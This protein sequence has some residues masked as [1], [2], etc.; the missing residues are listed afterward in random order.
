MPLT[1]QSPIQNQGSQPLM[2]KRGVVEN[3]DGGVELF[4]GEFE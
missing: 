4:A 1:K 3:E 2:S